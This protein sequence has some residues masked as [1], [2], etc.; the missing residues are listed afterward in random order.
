MDSGLPIPYF[1]NQLQVGVCVC[2]CVFLCFVYAF[3]YKCECVE[4]CTALAAYLVYRFLRTTIGTCAAIH[5]IPV[6]C[7]HAFTLNL[8]IV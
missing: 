8:C 7:V 3:V 4:I 6:S 2:A 5:S 1:H